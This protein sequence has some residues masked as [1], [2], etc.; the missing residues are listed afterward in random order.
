MNATDTINAKTIIT[1]LI[2]HKYADDIVFAYLFGSAARG[3]ITLLSD[4]DIAVYFSSRSKGSYSDMKLTFYG[5]L[6]RTLK[7]NDIDLIILNS[8]RN[9]ILLDEITKTGV[10]LF[11]RDPDLRQEFECKILHQAIEF[12]IQRLAIMG[13]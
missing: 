7:R 8:L 9:I 3:E 10:L 2:R 12:K 6:C 11:D 4:I 13:I 5:D 1:N